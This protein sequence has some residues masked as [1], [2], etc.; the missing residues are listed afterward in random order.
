NLVYKDHTKAGPNS[1]RYS[2]KVSASPS[3]AS[4][5]KPSQSSSNDKV[6]PCSDF[7]KGQDKDGQ[8]FSRVLVSLT[9]DSSRG[10]IKDPTSSGS[11]LV[12]D[13]TDFSKDQ[14]SPSTN[15]TKGQVRDSTSSSKSQE[16][17]L[18]QDSIKGQ[19]KTSPTSHKDSSNGQVISGRSA[20]KNLEV[21][22]S[23]SSRRGQV[24][25]ASASHKDQDVK[26]GSSSSKDSCVKATLGSHNNPQTTASSESNKALKNTY[27]KLPFIS[28]DEQEN[29]DNEDPRWKEQAQLSTSEERYR[30]ARRLWKNPCVP[31]PNKNLT[32]FSSK[33]LKACQSLSF[34][35][36]RK[37]RRSQWCDIDN[38]QP[39]RK[40]QRRF[41]NLAFST[42]H[43]IRSKHQVMN[44]FLGNIQE[45]NIS[46]Q[47]AK[48][49][50]NSH[51]EKQYMLDLALEEV[52]AI[53]MFYDGL[54]DQ[55]L[56][57]T[58]EEVEMGWDATEHVYHVFGHIYGYNG[59]EFF[60]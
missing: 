49:L 14:I 43:I 56:A 31:D 55:D 33:Q 10:Q 42:N 11:S 17:K 4:H 29:K 1:S 35:S 8:S 34:T 16:E 44:E 51:K 47:A 39:L 24:K 28:T 15:S 50:E 45:P 23:D 25:E 7:S 48:K 26:N 58:Q 60:P 30:L 13:G 41:E 12:K 27:H 21:K 32:F 3:K 53:Q 52:N 54:P 38:L 22:T 2:K 6:S 18:S 46:R 57:L 19:F 37:R 36:S 20:S 40:R 9:T 5:I 59:Q